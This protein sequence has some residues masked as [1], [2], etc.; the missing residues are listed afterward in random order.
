M[1]SL[2]PGTALPGDILDEDVT[3]VPAPL[4]H[5]SPQDIW[6]EALLQATVSRPE[7]MAWV[8]RHTTGSESITE[9]R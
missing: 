4:P 9:G 6:L 1:R 3:A 7:L 8:V 5:H 2:A